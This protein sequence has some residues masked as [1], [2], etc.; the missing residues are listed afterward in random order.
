MKKYKIALAGNPNVGKTCIFNS[1]TGSNQHVGNWPGVTVERK[2]GYITISGAEYEIVDLP[3]IYSFSPN[4]L[5]E[6]ISRDF[7]VE[8]KPDAVILVVDASNLERNL[9]IL[10]QALE[11]KKKV[12]LVM[13]MMDIVR[14][15]NIKIDIEGLKKI[16]GIP[17]IEAC[18]SKCEG[19]EEIK[20][21]LAKLDEW[22]IPEF[23]INYGERVDKAID[24]LGDFFEKKGITYDKRWFA[25]KTL[26]DDKQILAL[27]QGRDDSAE[28]FKEID[29]AKKEIEK[30]VNDLDTFFIEKKYGFVSGVVHECVKK[31]SNL[32]L[33]MD[34]TEKIDSVLTNRLL[35]IPL[36]IAMM[37][38]TFQFVF[39]LGDPM[40]GWV[41]TIIGFISS[42]VA[43]I[44]GKMGVPELI[45]SL[46]TDGIIEG[47]GSVLTFI[48]VIALLYLA[49][50]ILEDTGYMSRAAFVMDKFM[51]MLGLHGKSFIPMVVGFGCTV[52]GVMATR[53]LESKKDRLITI[54]ILPFMSCG[55]KLPIYALFTAAFFGEN[56]G[57]VVFAMYVIGIATAVIMARL[58]KSVFFKNEMSP[59]IMEL[60]PY[61]L[62][63]LKNLMWKVW[64][65]CTLFVRKAGTVIL[66]GVTVIWFLGAFPQNVDIEHTYLAQVGKVVAPIFKPAGFGNW[67]SSV[68][69]TSGLVAKEIVVG[70]FG[71]IYGLSENDS[72]DEGKVANRLRDSGIFT[73]LTAF[74]FMVFSL[75]Y[76]PCMAAVGAIKKEAGW[77]WAI[78]ATVYTTTTAWVAA[79]LIYQ[80]GS[81]I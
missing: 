5:D 19:N 67:E 60:P 40:I 26:E 59:L 46:A 28:L 31:S 27:I 47:V 79:V 35:G 16:L 62:P 43:T 10:T 41:E 29:L 2:E 24:I 49:I 7:L 25:I 1:L 72:E 42:G 36:F 76:V 3:G 20:K 38:F 45:I 34:V 11:L 80:V 44:L 12:I 53:T 73:P 21:E 63:L 51:H 81:L 32:K 66:L 56:A 33:R 55:A 4:T 17:V 69:L 14:K 71:T 48:P 30:Y 78:F 68:A 64:Y 13:N 8:E 65:R 75:L 22:E 77:N 37:Y 52:P 57:N 9:Y 15:E 58:L 54:L 70:T 18:A 61:R 23:R 6:K 74:G 39:K 50:G